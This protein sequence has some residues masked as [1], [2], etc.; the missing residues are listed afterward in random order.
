MTSPQPARFIC[1]ACDAPS[2]NPNDLA[3]GY[4]GRCHR[5]TADRPGEHTRPHDVE[6]IFMLKQMGRQLDACY[7]QLR[8]DGHAYAYTAA[9]TARDA[10]AE[11]VTQLLH[12]NGALP[13]T[14]Q[15]LA[16][17]GDVAPRVV[18][19]TVTGSR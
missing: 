2:S 10:V 14:E 16:R 12:D 15:W 1:P 18:D 13:E 9:V 19:G 6:L 3:N 17:A 8:T 7:Q 11:L 4:C 5:F